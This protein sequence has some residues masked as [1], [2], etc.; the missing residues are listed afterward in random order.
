M[1]QWEFWRGGFWRRP[2]LVALLSLALIAFVPVALADISE[3]SAV[4]DALAAGRLC[5]RP[6]DPALPCLDSIPGVLDGPHG[7][8]SPRTEW[9]LYRD[10]GRPLLHFDVGLGSDLTN[11]ERAIALTYQDERVAEVFVADHSVR[12]R[13]VGTRGSALDVGLALIALLVG[14]RGVAYAWASWRRTGSVVAVEGHGW[15]NSGLSRFCK[16]PLLLVICAV[17]AVWAV[18]FLLGS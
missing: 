15:D 7:S 18:V 2:V 6:H 3:A 4:G 8:R 14:V 16:L 11:G 12:A 1:R 17:G 10:D 5:T 13:S 9:W